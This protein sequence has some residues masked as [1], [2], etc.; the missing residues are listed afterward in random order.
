MGKCNC[1]PP[2]NKPVTQN[3]KIIYTRANTGHHPGPGLKNTVAF[4]LGHSL[5]WVVA[6]VVIMAG[7][8]YKKVGSTPKTIATKRPSD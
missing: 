8:F 3:R 6:F 7:V 2:E 4:I 5:F 1:R